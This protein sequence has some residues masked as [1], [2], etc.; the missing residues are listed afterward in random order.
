MLRNN[1]EEFVCKVRQIP[2]LFAQRRG[3]L[4]HAPTPFLQGLPG[5]ADRFYFSL[6][7][8]SQ[9]LEYT[10]DAT[11]HEGDHQQKDQIQ[12]LL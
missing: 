8:I 7:G 4:Q 3:R 1:V 6:S 5:L 9:R 12:N 11:A 10:N 2:G